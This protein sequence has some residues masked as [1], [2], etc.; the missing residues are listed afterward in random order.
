MAFNPAD[1]TVEEPKSI[2]VV[3]LLDTSSSMQ[4]ESII[5]LNNAVE[6]MITKFKEAETLETFIKLSIITFGNEDVQLHTPL[7]E[8]STIEF[9]KLNPGGM[10]PMGKA[11]RMAKEMIEDKVIFKGRDYRPAV[12]L[13]SDGAPND[14]W[15]KSL[16][17]FVGNGRSSKCDRLAVAIGDDAD[18]VVLEKFI[19]GNENSLFLAEDASKIMDVFKKITMSVSM[20]TK[21]VNKNAPINID[22]SLSN[23]DIDINDLDSFK[24][25]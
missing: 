4:G 3:L 6:L 5:A 22:E 17:N 13:L 1:F 2:P 25:D 11:L 21:S 24:F 8:V 16:D 15:E 20:R 12:I 18:K 14:D 23:G 9:E 10:T 19:S 7:K